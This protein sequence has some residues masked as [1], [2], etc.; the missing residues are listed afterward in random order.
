[1]CAVRVGAGAPDDDVVEAVAV[2]VPGRGDGD[3]RCVVIGRR[4][5]LEAVVAVER[6]EVE[7]G[8]EA[9]GLA[10]HD[11]ARRSRIRYRRRVRR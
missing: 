11:I 6:G 3:A 9:A 7:V 5:Q 2:H 10:E 8:V 4:C 1:M